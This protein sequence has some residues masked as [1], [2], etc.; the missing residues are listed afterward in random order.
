MAPD[1]FAYGVGYGVG[2]LIPYSGLTRLTP[3]EAALAGRDT[4]RELDI[5]RCSGLFDAAFYL[6]A[7]PDIASSGVEPL[8]HYHLPAAAMSG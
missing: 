4:A 3:D 2:Q 5:L 1:D 8:T 7:N 6:H